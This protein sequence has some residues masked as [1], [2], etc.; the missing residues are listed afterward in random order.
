MVV[1]EE[2]LLTVKE[3]A[4][5]L[6]VHEN[7]VLSWLKRGQLRGSRLGGTKSGWRIRAS[8][9]DRFLQEREPQSERPE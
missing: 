9:I 5:Q 6:R 3:V 2:R 4:A 8:E 7:T 1:V